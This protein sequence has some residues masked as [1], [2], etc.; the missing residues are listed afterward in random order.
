[1]VLGTNAVVDPLAV[2]IE[3]VDALVA[4]VAVA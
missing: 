2:V 3:S 1:M 4:D